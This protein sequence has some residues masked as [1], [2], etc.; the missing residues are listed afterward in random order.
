M[1]KVFIAIVA[2]LLCF[3][4]V[5]ANTEGKIKINIIL[6]EQ[7]NA[8]ELNRMGD[9]YATKAER[10]DFVVNALKIRRKSRS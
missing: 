9:S 10:R 7:S 3:A 8:M 6:N 2:I 4:G 1:K 5:S